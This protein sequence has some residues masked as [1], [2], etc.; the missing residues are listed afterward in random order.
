MTS[1]QI[2]SVI[3][4]GQIFNPYSDV[5]ST[6]CAPGE[7]YDQTM[8][9]C[10]AIQYPSVPWYCDWIPNAESLFADCQAAKLPLPPPPEAVTH[11]GVSETIPPTTEQAQA[12]INASLKVAAEKAQAQNLEAFQGMQPLFAPKICGPFSTPVTQPD[13]SYKCTFDPT[14]IPSW[15]LLVGAAVVG[16]VLF[17]GL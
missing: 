10:R 5:R 4:M 2:G 17:R 1:T 8:G 15:I 9:F 3:G 16:V 11:Y 12:A 6:Q 14:N 7:T 13:G